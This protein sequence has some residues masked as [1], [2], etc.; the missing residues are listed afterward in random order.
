MQPINKLLPQVNGA[1]PAAPK[2]SQA[3]W[4]PTAVDIDRYIKDKGWPVLSDMQID[5]LEGEDLSKLQSAIDIVARWLQ[6]APTNLGLSILLIASPVPDDQNRTGYGC[7]K[8]MLAKIA[9]YGFADVSY[10]AGERQL[11]VMPKGR[12]VSSRDL[13]AKFDEE[14]AFEFW[15]KGRGLLVIDDVGREGSLR[16]E[17]RDPDLQLQEKQDRYYTAINWCYERNISLILTSNMTSR[18][19]ANFLG[20]A[21]WSRLLER[22]PTQYRINLT[23]V[24]DMR[25]TLAESEEWF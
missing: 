11:W 24:P 14:G 16:F 19:L 6:K 9:Y 23:G 18:E 3:D 13:M 4:Q 15:M 8:T 1:T 22:C 2:T 21:T 17:R 12:F 10:V 25:P 5:H 7:G 20:G